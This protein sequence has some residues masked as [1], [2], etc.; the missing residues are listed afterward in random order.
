LLE[1]SPSPLGVARHRATRHKAKAEEQ[2]LEKGLGMTKKNYENTLQ[3]CLDCLHT[4]QKL[5]IQTLVFHYTD[6]EEFGELDMTE[7]SKC[8]CEYCGSNLAGHRFTASLPK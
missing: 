1:I 2:K 6:S 7:F 5:H 8:P 4:N 3:V